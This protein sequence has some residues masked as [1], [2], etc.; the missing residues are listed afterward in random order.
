MKLT[1]ERITEFK[2]LAEKASYSGEWSQ[3]RHCHAWYGYITRNYIVLKSYATIVAVLD[4]REDV[5]YELGKW[6]PTTSRQVTW[7]T[8]LFNARKEFVE[9]YD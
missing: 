2:K 5:V 3:L 8:Q 1:P 7:F 9:N 6:S 4:L